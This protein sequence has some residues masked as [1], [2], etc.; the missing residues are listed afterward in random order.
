MPINLL[1]PILNQNNTLLQTLLYC[2]VLLVFL[3]WRGSLLVNLAKIVRK[4]LKENIIFLSKV[5]MFSV[6]VILSYI[7][8]IGGASTQFLVVA[9]ITVGG[10]IYAVTVQGKQRIAEYP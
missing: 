2:G 9:T 8:S 10:I 5:M 6:V 1:E 7:N 4:S 3:Y